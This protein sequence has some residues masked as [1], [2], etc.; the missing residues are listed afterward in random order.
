LNNNNNNNNKCVCRFL[1]NSKEAFITDRL[2]EGEIAN[3]AQLVT[4]VTV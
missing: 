2:K 1:A 4:R 3:D